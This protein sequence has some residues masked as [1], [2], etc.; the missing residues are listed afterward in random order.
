MFMCTL[1]QDS[2]ALTVYALTEEKLVDLPAPVNT[3]DNMPG[4]KGWNWVVNMAHYIEQLDAVA[5]AEYRGTSKAWAGAFVPPS[6]EKFPCANDA[7][8]DACLH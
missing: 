3:T 2:Y 6:A 5:V 8:S 1:T 7:V 4:A